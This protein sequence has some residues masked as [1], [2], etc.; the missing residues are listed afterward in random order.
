M[1][2]A[3]LSPELFALVLAALAVDLML[4]DPAWCPHPVVLM[5]RVIARLET[6]WNH[7]DDRSR[8]RRG[9][10]L[11]GV[12]VLGTWAIAG[13]VIA[14][15]G[16]VSAW[17]S[18]AI[19]LILL[20]LS[21]ATR[22]LVQAAYAVLAPLSAGDLA[23]ARRAVGRIV[24]RDTR[25]LDDAGVTRACVE[26]VAENTVDGITA[27]L[28][29]A[30]IGGAPLALAYKA[31][32]TLDSMVGYRNPRY[33][34]FG[35]ASAR[36]D[37]AANWLPARLTAF[38]MWALAALVPGDHRDGAWRKTWRRAWRETRR[39]APRHPSPNSG[40][41][42]AMVAWLIG[43][44]LGGINRY[45]AVVSERARLGEA[46]EPLTAV[47]IQRAIACLHAGWLG[48]MSL[49]AALVAVLALW[50]TGGAG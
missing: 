24:G 12:V 14:L 25:S 6:A 22:G 29:W 13:A 38:A 5:G 2:F 20:S 44:E 10:W 11:A 26:S 40:W 4:G 48:V 37:D 32:N 33:L 18:G 31:I 3:P 15:A 17:L 9:R 41:P 28:F 21:L 45:G 36:L 34:D 47:H 46:R 30:L 7:G 50:P 19:E 23:Q 49:M 42:E 43:V 1:T 27:P 8:R 39:Q 35:R 16:W